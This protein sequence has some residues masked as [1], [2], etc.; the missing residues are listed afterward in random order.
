MTEA[1]APGMGIVWEVS[2]GSCVDDGIP[3]F[4]VMQ[5]K[6]CINNR[7]QLGLLGDICNKD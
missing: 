5:Y 4:A 7:G 2:S 3:A 1:A 6:S